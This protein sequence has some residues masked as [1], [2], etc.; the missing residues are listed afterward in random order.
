MYSIENSQ[1][2]TYSEQGLN[3]DDMEKNFDIESLLVSEEQLITFLGSILLMLFILAIILTVIYYRCRMNILK[4]KHITN[5]VE[6]LTDN[7][8]KTEKA[9]FN[10]YQKKMSADKVFM[11]DD[12]F[13][14]SNN[15]NVTSVNVDQVHSDLNTH[16]YTYMKP[17]IKKI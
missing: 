1:P 4:K 8:F 11:I 7:N 12:V 16:R 10:D 17:I 5:Q 2:L 13:K 6:M 3:I 9:P 15:P 14:V